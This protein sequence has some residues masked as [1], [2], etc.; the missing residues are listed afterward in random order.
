L[1]IFA[2]Y[3][4]ISILNKL[5]KMNYT[6]YNLKTMKHI[7][8]LLVCITFPIFL[9][10]QN[11]SGIINKYAAITAVDT[12]AGQINV[13]STTG[14]AVGDKVLLIQM[15][16]ATIKQTNGSEFGD[17]TSLRTV[18]KHEINQID[19]ISGTTVFLRFKLLNEYFTT[20]G[21]C[22]MVSFPKYQTA[23]VTDTIKAKPWDG[24][25]GGIIA[26]EATNL[27]LNAPIVA[28]EVGFRGGAIKS[29]NQCDAFDIYN[30]YYYALNSPN[31]DNG[32]PKG[33]GVALLIS[34]KECGKGAQANGGGGGN[35]H[36]SGGGGGANLTSGGNGGDSD[37]GI[38]GFFSRCPGT[39]PGKAGKGISNVPNDQ[40]FFGGGGGAGQNKEGSDSKGGN[41]GGII[42]IKA[43]SITGN[44]KKIVAKGGSSQLS[45]GDGAGGAGAGGTILIESKQIIG[46]LTLESMGGTGGNAVTGSS[47]D[48]G[49]GGGGAGGRIMIDASTS[50]STVLTGGNAGI[51]TGSNSSQNG[52][53]GNDGSLQKIA[54]LT[55]PTAKDTINRSFAITTQPKNVSICE[56]D[57]AKLSVKSTGLNLKY[58][59]QV[60]T[61]SGF[62]PLTETATYKGV[63]TQ[64]LAVVKANPNLNPNSYRCVVSSGCGVPR[65]INSNAISLII[66]TLP[67]P[68]FTYTTTN[69]TVKFTNG[70]TNADTYAW[71]FGNGKTDITAN[72]THTFAQQ[73][74]YRVVLKATNGCGTK[75]YSTVVNLNAPPK[76][77]FE[78]SSTNGCTTTPILFNNLS[79]DNVKKY[80]WSFPKGR[81]ATSEEKGPS[82]FY[83][84]S[85]V[86]DVILVVENSSGRDTFKRSGYIK[87]T[88]KP[89][90]NFTALADGLN[91]RFTNNS[92]NATTYLWQYGDNKTSQEANP[93]YIYPTGGT[94][95]VTMTA[96]NS[97]GSTTDTQRLVLY[98]LPSATVSVNQTKGCSPLSV[99]FAGKNVVGVTGWSW[100]FPGG[101]PS[102]STLPNPRVVYEQPGVY[103]VVL[104]VTNGAGTSSIKQD[105]F[106]RVVAAPKALFDVKVTQNVAEFTNRSI[107]SDKFTW[108]F[109]DG[110][111]SNE[112]NPPPHTYYQNKNFIVSLLVQNTACAS[113]TERQV[114]IFGLTPTNDIEKETALKIYPN[115]TDGLL[116]LDFSNVEKIDYQLIVTNIQGQALKNQQLTKETLQ[117]VD[118][119]DLPKGIYFLAFKN[120]ATHFVKKVVRY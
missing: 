17:I 46:S 68:N 102:V 22:Q 79:S 24:A 87:I 52:G 27:T 25:S 82:V 49:P 36:K 28:S 107:N 13:N 29:Y 35:N 88:G 60:N 41:G 110:T 89:K 117:V 120:K 34:S 26:F 80:Y 10:G 70:S 63:A 20:E 2:P 19:S 61:G 108:D 69:N 51:G 81:P 83:D 33:E 42:L 30:S 53:R 113:A 31:K 1:V 105:S 99:E 71:T 95:I 54:N 48:F 106:I 40:I 116:Y 44:N 72:P 38:T 94:Y 78:A 84:S 14:F 45:T 16:G 92:S 21:V 64:N 43:T 6:I 97:C 50:P 93:T 100:S 12:C 67:V 75:E 96:T 8:T 86:Y 56:G 23:T 58:Q 18:G 32:G 90:A 76:S 3:Q 15:S 47:Y 62:V 112:R 4:F 85:G 59:W 5:K 101:T 114:P 66:N 74:T 7:F 73:D 55:I 109:G 65:A 118:M 57:T 119:N 111:N 77:N 91:V 103:D 104:S 37:R 98:S 9:Q 11:I 39:N 115:P